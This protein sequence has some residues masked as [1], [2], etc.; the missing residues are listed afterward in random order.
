MN[1]FRNAQDPQVLETYG[2]SENSY[3][4]SAPHAVV[5]RPRSTEEVSAIVKVA[6]KYRVPVTPYG[7]GTSLEG[8]FSGV[9]PGIVCSANCERD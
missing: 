1:E 8:H 6:N 5:V 2:F 7:A 9:R 3:H 4:P